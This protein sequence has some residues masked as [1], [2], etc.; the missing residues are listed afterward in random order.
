MNNK[1]LKELRRIRRK[2]NEKYEEAMRLYE[3]SSA[4]DEL[5][6]QGFSNFFETCDFVKRRLGKIIVVELGSGDERVETKP[7]FDC[8]HKRGAKTI[9]CSSNN[10]PLLK[11]RR[12]KSG[13]SKH[14][15]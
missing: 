15:K 6:N 13:N 5:L 12:K 11:V 10:C 3:E 9:Y 4:M 7:C 8:G 1:L 14:D 2:S